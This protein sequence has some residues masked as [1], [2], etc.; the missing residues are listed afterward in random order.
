MD[1]GPVGVIVN[2][3]AGRGRAL[4]LLPRVVASFAAMRA[5]HHIYVTTQPGEASAVAHRFVSDGMR[6]VVAV[7]G[8]GT[9]NEVVNGLLTARTATPAALGIVPAGRAADIV[10]NLGGALNPATALCRDPIDDV[11]R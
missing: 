1:W 6:L 7:G 4:R 2:P 8:D 5:M 11:G 3:V 10:R 9:V